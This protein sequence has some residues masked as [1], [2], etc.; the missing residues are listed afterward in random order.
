MLPRPDAPARKSLALYH[1]IS[2]RFRRGKGEGKQDLFLAGMEDYNK[3]AETRGGTG[4]AMEQPQEAGRG[5]AMA[6]G[7]GRAPAGAFE[8][9]GMR[10]V[11][12][13]F[14][15]PAREVRIAALLEALKYGGEGLEFLLEAL[16]DGEV[17]VRWAA[18]RLL[19]V[20][21]EGK[22]R[23]RIEKWQPRYENECSPLQAAG[24]PKVKRDLT[25]HL[26]GAANTHC[27]VPAR[28]SL[29]SPR[30]HA[31]PPC[32]QNSRHSK[33]LHPTTASSPAD[34]A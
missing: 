6:E 19:E 5:K 17:A 27:L 8:G 11:R 13:R 3:S 28:T 24:Y 12:E 15:N 21:P 1:S 14:C 20:R 31:F 33:T 23:E 4:G 2:C 16:E 30:L 32:S 18:Y 25:A 10:G 7:R 22:V 29:S 26:G 9:E 34:T